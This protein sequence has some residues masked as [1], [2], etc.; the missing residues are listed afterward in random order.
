MAFEN[1]TNRKRVE[2]IVEIIELINKSAQSNKV[3][4]EELAEMLSPVIS[5]T[6][7]V[8]FVETG[9]PPADSVEPPKVRERLQRFDMELAD[10]CRD[11]PLWALPRAMAVIMNRVD[12]LIAENEEGK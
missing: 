11:A 6:A 1:P 7:G 4:P 2:K 9:E 12:E 10:A 8:R 3:T 5:A